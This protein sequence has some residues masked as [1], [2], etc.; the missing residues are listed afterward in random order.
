MVGD[1][2]ASIQSSTLPSCYTNSN[3]T[4]P[5]KNYS[6]LGVDF[7]STSKKKKLLTYMGPLLHVLE[8]GGNFPGMMGMVS[9]TNT[10]AGISANATATASP[11]I[12]DT[13]ARNFSNRSF[14]FHALRR[15]VGSLLLIELADTLF[16]IL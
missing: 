13:E 12:S 3:L 7:D 14:Q 16:S 10:I 15:Q 6:N 4:K 8:Q 11:Q 1:E 2:Q 5:K 9:T